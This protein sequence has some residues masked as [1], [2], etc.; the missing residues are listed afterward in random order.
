MNHLTASYSGPMETRYSLGCR[1]GTAV[2]YQL[3]LTNQVASQR[4]DVASLVFA[5]NM[6]SHYGLGLLFHTG[7]STCSTDFLFYCLSIPEVW[8]AMAC[9]CSVCKLSVSLASYYSP[10]TSASSDRSFSA[11][12]AAFSI[13][14]WASISPT[15]RHHLCTLPSSQSCGQL[16]LRDARS[17]P[18]AASCLVLPDRT[19]GI[20]YLAT[21][22]YRRAHRSAGGVPGD[23]DV[24]NQGPSLIS[25]AACA[26]TARHRKLGLCYLGAACFLAVVCWFGWR[27]RALAVLAGAVTFSGCLQLPVPWCYGIS[28]TGKWIFSYKQLAAVLVPTF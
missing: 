11:C 28:E 25:S 13:C 18:L 7:P 1:P 10:Y 12:S 16:T 27:G 22:F 3:Q 8:T 2:L 17:F 21:S 20:D 15:T 4:P 6:Q 26:K 24:A 5:G 19:F 9:G 23:L 14:S